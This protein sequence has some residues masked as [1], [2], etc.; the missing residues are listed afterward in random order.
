MKLGCQ[1]KDHNITD[2][3]FYESMLI[4]SPDTYDLRAG[5]PI[6]HLITVS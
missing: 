3:Q 2:R 6:S 1:L 5:I 4:K